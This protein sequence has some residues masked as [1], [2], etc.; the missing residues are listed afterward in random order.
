MKLEDPN[1][2]TKLYMA[3]LAPSWHWV[4]QAFSSDPPTQRPY[5]VIFSVGETIVSTTQDQ[6][7]L[8]PSSGVYGQISKHSLGRITAAADAGIAQSSGP[9]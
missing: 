9:L 7:E 2:T 3:R 8:F 6:H 1:T 5:S 4:N